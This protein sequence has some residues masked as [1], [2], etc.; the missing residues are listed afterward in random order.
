[1]GEKTDFGAEAGD[2]AFVA[3]GIKVLSAKEGDL[4]RRC[5]QETC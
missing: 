1:M 5:L 3:G 4:R 2:D